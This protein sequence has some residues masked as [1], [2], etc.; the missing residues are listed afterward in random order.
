MKGTTKV[1]RKTTS[2]NTLP[3]TP[4]DKKKVL[5]YG[6]GGG[7]VLGLGYLAYSFFSNRAANRRSEEMPEASTPNVS[8]PFIPPASSRQF[9]LRKGA[10]G[11]MVELLQKALLQKGGQ[12]GLI[13]RETSFRN[14][15]VDGIFG[16]GTQKALR[17]AGFPSALSQNQFTTLVGKHT[18]AKGQQLAGIAK[19]LIDAA[20]TQNLFAVLQGLKQIQSVAQ[21]KQVS[22]YFQNVRILGT[23]V[24]SLVNALLSVAFKNKEIE[25]VKIRA[26][27]RRMGL[28]QNARGIW[29]ISKSMGNLMGTF[30][31]TPDQ[32]QHEWNVA[33]A[34]KPTLLKAKDGSFIIPELLPNTVIGYITGMQN[35]ITEILTQTG[36]TVYAPSKNL[37]TL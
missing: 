30:D 1:S 33:I 7:L 20:N 10:R 36:E 27:F 3:K 12:A 28:S 26:Q 34:Q 15:K 17:A 9:P 25:K 11:V 35:G 37:S 5:M 13:I 6:I 16:S 2:K 21:Y 22:L 24:T 8:A 29:F 32:I 14:G 4:M 18:S 23:R 31:R 19:S